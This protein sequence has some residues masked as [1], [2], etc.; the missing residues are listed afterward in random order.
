MR[1]PVRRSTSDQTGGSTYDWSSTV[2]AA[3]S[4]SV[5]GPI[6]TVPQSNAE[7]DHEALAVEG[8]ERHHPQPVLRLR[9][10][11]EHGVP[12]EG[13]DPLE[14]L[15]GALGPGRRPGRV[16]LVG[17]AGH[18]AAGEPELGGVVVGDQQQRV[19]AVGKHRVL[20]VVLDARTPAAHRVAAAT[21]GIAASTTHTSRVSRLSAQITTRAPLRVARTFSSKRSSGS[22]STS[23]SSATGVPSACR[24]TWNG[25]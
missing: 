23:T 9:P 3:A 14:P 12:G 5:L 6:S 18:R 7:R 11:A 15:V 1:S 2:T 16:V 21:S 13:V 20:G 8:V 10:E 25:R 19:R 24:H 4:Y 17:V 22:S